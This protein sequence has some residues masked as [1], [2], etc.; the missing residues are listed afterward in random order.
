MIAD[1]LGQDIDLVK[2]DNEMVWEATPDNQF[3]TYYDDDGYH[4][5]SNTSAQL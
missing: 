3:K 4:V 2:E 1:K 5:L